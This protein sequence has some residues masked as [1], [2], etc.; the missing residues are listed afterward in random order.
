VVPL[1][2]LVWTSSLLPSYRPAPSGEMPITA[3]ITLETHGTGTRYVATCLHQDMVGRDKHLA[4][5]F[6][7]GW[8]IALD[9]LVSHVKLAMPT[10]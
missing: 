6:H 3:I 2:R 1:E 8:G 4:M 5:G 10:S 9:Q 7:E